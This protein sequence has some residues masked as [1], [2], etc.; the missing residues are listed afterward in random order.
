MTDRRAL[1]V[2]EAFGRARAATPKASV[3]LGLRRRHFMP[4]GLAA[5]VLFGAHAAAD[6]VDDHLL[7]IASGI[8]AGMDSV[9]ASWEVTRPMV[10]WVGV[11]EGTLFARVLTLLWE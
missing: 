1:G 10:N 7:T 8:D 3:W 2:G 6:T 4:A 5:M 11:A 9:L